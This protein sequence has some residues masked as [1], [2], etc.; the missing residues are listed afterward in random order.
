MMVRPAS[1]GYN[2]ETAG[3]NRFQQRPAA[4]G[5]AEAVAARREFDGFAGAS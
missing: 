1:F 5:G 2:P 4:A 3:T